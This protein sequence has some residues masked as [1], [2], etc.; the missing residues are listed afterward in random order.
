[1][2]S[3]ELP[4]PTRSIDR[5]IENFD[6]DPSA[7][8]AEASLRELIGAFPHNVNVNHVLLKIIAINRLYRARVLDKDMETFVAHVAAI[9]NLDDMLKSG[10]PEAVTL[11]CDSPRPVRRYYSFAT[12]YC[13]WHNQSAYS[14][15]DGYVDEALW[16]YRK[17]DRFKEFKR[18]SLQ[19]YMELLDVTHAFRTHYGLQNY[20]L[21]D[22]D[23]FLWR[24]G[25]AVSKKVTPSA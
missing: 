11:I 9:P 15:W 2:E 19:E 21:K 17:Q 18:E 20:S 25:S 4:C 5:E 6:L 8:L 23:K 3:K 1:M 24:V 13:S 22:I 7:A 12:K 10:N 16:A 14:M